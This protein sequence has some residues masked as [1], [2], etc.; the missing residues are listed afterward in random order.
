MN[1]EAK[2]LPNILWL[3]LNIREFKLNMSHL[4]YDQIRMF[5]LH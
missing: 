3:R 1:I 4:S 2:I 5:M